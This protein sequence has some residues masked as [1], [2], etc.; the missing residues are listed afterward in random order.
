MTTVKPAR[1]L[2]RSSLAGA[3]IAAIG[4][5]VSACSTMMAPPG[6]TPASSK[7]IAI[8][9]AY[10]DAFNTRNIEAMGVLMDD[11]IQWLAIDGDTLETVSSG[12]EALSEDMRGYFNSGTDVLSTL[13]GISQTGPFVSTVETASWTTSNGTEKS[14]ASI[15]IYEVT[16]AGL[17]RRVWYF[18][19]VAGPA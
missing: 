4:L 19:E 18:P 13:S 8:V 7:E 9:Q 16:G 6:Q 1:R 15:A 5:L 14:Q 10:V 11:D 2:A 3:L 12:R 17:I